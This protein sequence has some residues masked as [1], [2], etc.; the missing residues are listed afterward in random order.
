MSNLKSLEEDL[1]SEVDGDFLKGLKALLKPTSVYEAE[2]LQ[3]SM[4][5]IVEKIAFKSTTWW[6]FTIW[7]LGH[8]RTNYVRIALHQEWPRNKR[9]SRGIS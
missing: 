3:K 4:K 6:T 5:V 2:C 9:L 1:E 8:K 7:G